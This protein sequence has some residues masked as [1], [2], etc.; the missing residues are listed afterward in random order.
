MVVLGW[1]NIPII[2]WSVDWWYTLHQPASLLRLAKPAIHGQYL[3][4]L[5]IMVAGFVFYTFTVGL[6]RLC[7]MIYQRRKGGEGL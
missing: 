7:L 3:G 5:F 1:I 6:W 4:P 2:K